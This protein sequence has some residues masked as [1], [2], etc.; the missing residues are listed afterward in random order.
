MN[1]L[2]NAKKFKKIVKLL[3]RKK[4]CQIWWKCKT[5]LC[6][7][8]VKFHIFFRPKRPS[9]FCWTEI[10]TEAFISAETETFRRFGRTLI[11][12]LFSSMENIF[13][14]FAGLTL[15]RNF[16]CNKKGLLVENFIAISRSLIS[17]IWTFAQILITFKITYFMLEKILSSY[18]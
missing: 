10:S 12:F 7:T 17:F 9:E 8:V 13:L 15:D 18:K 2:F 5:S 11:V 14:L 4:I 3:F 16:V 6:K 1:L